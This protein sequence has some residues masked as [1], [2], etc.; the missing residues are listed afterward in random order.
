MPESSLNSSKLAPA[1]STGLQAALAVTFSRQPG[2]IRVLVARR[3][4]GRRLA[5][6]WEWP[7]GKVEP[8]ET[9]EQ[10]VRRELLEET[11]IVAPTLGVRPLCL[12]A[13]PGPPRIDFHVFLIELPAPCL[14]AATEA[15]DPAWMTLREALEL[16][17]PQANR[18]INLL[19]AAALRE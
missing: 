10:A 13:D 8:G 4:P 14:P 17:F 9:P 16:D 19:I 2:G 3:R 11:G 12:H 1:G 5:G 7:G 18:P 15:S 6:L